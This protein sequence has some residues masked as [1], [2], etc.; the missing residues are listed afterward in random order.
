MDRRL[1]CVA[2]AGSLSALAA[3]AAP[4][5]APVVPEGNYGGGTIVDPPK[6]PYEKGNAVVTLRVVGS[7]V[8]V[9]AR[10]G[11][12]CD[13]RTFPAQA[14]L[15]ADGSFATSGSYSQTVPKGRVR[16]AYKLTGTVGAA[17]AGGTVSTRTTVTR[18]GR[19]AGRCG[20]GAIAWIARLPTGQIGAPGPP[21]QPGA[22]MYGTTSQLVG[23]RHHGI[24]LRFSADGTRL[25]RA[26][27]ALN[28]NC[29]H[30]PGTTS[31]DVPG[32]SL[33]ITPG[34]TVSDVERFTLKLSA[35][36]RVRLIERFSATVGSAGA[37]GTFQDRARYYDVR[38]NR[39]LDRCDT[40]RVKWTAAL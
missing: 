38:T 21:G 40:G 36:V 5:Q 24:V 22:R 1:V 7:G 27:Y 15:A 2:L 13:A 8:Q 17:G 25:T 11:S 30:P 35:R 9:L 34:G 16:V 37:T 12:T 10:T 19:V 31:F 26:L 4:A 39:T 18:R 28:E 14:V 29:H 23:K 3:A 20:S 33:A 32:K 6:S